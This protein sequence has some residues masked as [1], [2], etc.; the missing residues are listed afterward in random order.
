MIR[1]SPVTACNENDNIFTNLL[2]SH[3]A[4]IV[5]TMT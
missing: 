1:Y 4:C 2:M 3:V 5:P